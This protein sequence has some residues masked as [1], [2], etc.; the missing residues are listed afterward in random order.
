MQ[1]SGSPLRY[2]EGGD[3]MSYESY[4]S[5]ELD[6]RHKDFARVAKALKSQGFRFCCSDKHALVSVPFDPEKDTRAD[7]EVEYYCVLNAKRIGLETIL[8]VNSNRR[9]KGGCMENCRII[10]DQKS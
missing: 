3:N 9:S 2:L 1:N 6:P 10:L 7:P 5:L 4:I 8:F